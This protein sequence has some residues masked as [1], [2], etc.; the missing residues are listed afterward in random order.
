MRKETKNVKAELKGVHFKV[1]C[2]FLYE[3]KKRLTIFH[4]S[5]IIALQMPAGTNVERKGL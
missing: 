2:L 5:A 4:K 1:L 3:N